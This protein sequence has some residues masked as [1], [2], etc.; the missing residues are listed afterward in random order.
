MTPIPPGSDDEL[1][2]AVEENLFA[3]FRSMTQVLNGDLEENAQLGRYH[4]SPSSPIFK[5]VFQARL[6]PE[7]ADAAIDETIAWFQARQAPFF[8]W[9]TGPDSQ[10]TDL[11]QRLMARG[12]DEFEKNAPAMVADIDQL[13]WN[14]P[15]PSDLRLAPIAN[16]QELLQWKQTF[17]E[18][19]GLPEFAG[20]AW[21]EAT[22]A[23]G[24]GQTPWHLLLGTLNSEPVC[25]GLLYCGA[26]VAGLIGLGTL[27]AHRRKGIGSAMQ[28]E[29]LRMAR[30]LGYRHAVLFASEMGYS[31]YLKLGF[32]DTG[33]RISRYLWRNGV[34]LPR[35]GQAH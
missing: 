28:L 24:I 12:L 10:P 2:A 3:M 9:W 30:A 17:I 8:F 6:T 23:V 7:T 29:R 27:P 18:A 21:V 26:G 5:G 13:N 20:Q 11:G 25:C 16:E 4:A 33:R 34:S 1:A 31:P 15:R 35:I 32:R 22:Q 19:F 14:N